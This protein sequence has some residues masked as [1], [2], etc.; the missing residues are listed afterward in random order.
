MPEER[1]Y[2]HHL[3]KAVRIDADPETVFAF[4]DDHGRLV[5]HMDRPS[6]MMLGGRMSVSTDEGKGQAV[7]SHIRMGGSVLGMRLE[8]DEVVTIRE[9]PRRKSWDTVGEPR[10]LVIGPYRLGFEIEPAGG[11]S[12]LRVSIDYDLPMRG[13]W[14]GTLFGRNYANW[15][16]DQMLN[17]AKRHFETRSPVGGR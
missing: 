17:D 1:N 4:L 3:D 15:C 9:P 5:A 7:G 8:L 10:L 2:A 14:L 6:P 13:R 16:V 12:S 11:H